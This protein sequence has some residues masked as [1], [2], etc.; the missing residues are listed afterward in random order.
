MLT[1][2]KYRLHEGLQ[3]LHLPKGA[4]ILHFNSQHSVPTIWCLVDTNQ[5]KDELCELVVVGTGQEAPSLITHTYIGSALFER[6]TVVLHLF[7]KDRI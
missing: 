3:Q 4:K 7:E 2:F 1:I 6:D 5:L